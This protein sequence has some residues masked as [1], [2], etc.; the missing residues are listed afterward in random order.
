MRVGGNGW[1]AGA[2]G[3]GGM[4]GCDTGLEETTRAPD[5]VMAFPQS[6][7]NWAAGSFSRPQKSQAVR[8]GTADMMQ[9]LRRIYGR[10]KKGV[11]EEG[12]TYWD[13]PPP[14]FDRRPHLQ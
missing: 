1:P 10:R 4:G 3:F 12:R 9:P 11:N 14:A 5:A 8:G 6:M 2:G 13:E 7:Q